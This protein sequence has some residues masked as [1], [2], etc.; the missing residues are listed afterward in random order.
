VIERQIERYAPGFRDVIR[1][2]AVAGPPELAARNPNY[3]GGDIGC[4]RFAGLDAVFRPVV[5]RQPYAT[6]DPAVF[7]CS[8]A[9]PPGPGVHGMCGY[10]AARLALRRRFGAD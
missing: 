5:A 6:P 4:G 7:L 3:I 1:A 8:A 9:T 10:H 2:R